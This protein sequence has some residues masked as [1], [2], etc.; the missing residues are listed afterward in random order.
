[1]RLELEMDLNV[2][3]ADDFLLSNVVSNGLEPNYFLYFLST[4]HSNHCENHP[5]QLLRLTQHKRRL[6]IS[7]TS[8]HPT[9]F[10]GVRHQYLYFPFK[11]DYPRREYAENYS[12]NYFWLI[13]LSKLD[14]A[15]V[16]DNARYPVCCLTPRNIGVRA[17][18]SLYTQ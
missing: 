5:L 13:N 1:M 6:R 11:S 14:S 17:K 3:M 7:W 2:Y 16:V 12:S 18:T 8:E 15:R 4:Q 9:L 10:R